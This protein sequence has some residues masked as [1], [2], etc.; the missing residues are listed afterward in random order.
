MQYHYVSLHK[1]LNTYRI[2]IH[3]FH[4]WGR[5]SFFGKPRVVYGPFEQRV[6]GIGMPLG[7]RAVT[8]IS[9]MGA[10]L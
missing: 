3:F 1:S 10:G 9:E 7:M 5:N 4:Q 8:V 6:V 2:F